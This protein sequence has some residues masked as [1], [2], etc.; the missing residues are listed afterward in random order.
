MEAN[1]IDIAGGDAK[2]YNQNDTLASRED[3]SALFET[4]S[5]CKDKNNRAAVITAVSV[6]ANPDFNKIKE[7]DFNE[8]FHEHFTKTL[9]KYQG[10]S[11]AYDLWEEGIQNKIF[12]PQFH[13]REHLKYSLI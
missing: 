4:L 11:W 7:Y 13:G 8:Y 1:G 5:S 9:E 3:L 10:G 6:V 2:R 12:L